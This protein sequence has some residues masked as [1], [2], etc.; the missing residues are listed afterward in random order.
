MTGI[1]AALHLL[2]D[3]MC[4]L[5]MFGRLLPRGD[6]AL[7]ILLYNFCAFALQMP[8]G[9]ALDALCGGRRG[10]ETDFPFLFALAG[11]L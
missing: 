5:A 3:G 11:V 1:Y 2:V 9:V 7:A 8:L 6:R 10:R 4:A